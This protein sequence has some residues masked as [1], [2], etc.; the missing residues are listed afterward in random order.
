MNNVKTYFFL[1]L[2]KYLSYAGSYFIKS[3]LKYN[4]LKILLLLINNVMLI[5]CLC[6]TKW[7]AKFVNKS[8]IYFLLLVNTLL[9]INLIKIIKRKCWIDI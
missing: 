2:E 9:K 8:F 3:S 4:Y 5:L 7:S 6:S 1:I